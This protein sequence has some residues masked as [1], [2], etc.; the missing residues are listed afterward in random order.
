MSSKVGAAT[1]N[2][3]KKQTKDE[4]KQSVVPSSEPLTIRRIL[5]DES[6]AIEDYAPKAREKL[7]MGPILISIEE[8]CRAVNALIEILNANTCKAEDFNNACKVAAAAQVACGLAVIGLGITLCVVT[9]GIATPVVAVATLSLASTATGIAGGAAG[10]T[11]KQAKAKR[12]AKGK[13]ADAALDGAGLALTAAGGFGTST[14]LTEFS[15]G[16]AV[17]GGVLST[18]SGVGAYNESKV[19]NTNHLYLAIEGEFDNLW[20]NINN[21]YAAFTTA[22][23]SNEALMEWRS[24][25]SL[26]FNVIDLS[27]G[28]TFGKMILLKTKIGN[29][30]AGEFYKMKKAEAEAEKKEE[31][32]KAKAKVSNKKKKQQKNAIKP[33][34]V[35]T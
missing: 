18:L 33:F 32:K 16:V 35:E 19:Y 13:R 5:K 3:K 28:K 23:H 21:L 34:G 14:E 27:I 9:A 24:K 10:F 25:C 20:K 15:A 2:K 17:V 7:V 4:D 1:K 30:R 26:V 29:I 31:K 6:F 8:Y 11:A 12:D 22:M